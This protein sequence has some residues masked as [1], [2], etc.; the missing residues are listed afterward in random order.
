MLNSDDYSGNYIHYGVRE[1]ATAAIMNGMALHGGCIPYGGTFLVFSD[2]MRNSVR[3]AAMMGIKVV[4]VF[5]HDSIGLGE[6]GPT[7]QPIEHIASLRLI[8]NLT[9]IRPADANETAQAWKFALSNPSGP[10]ALMLTRQ[11]LPVVTD[12]VTAFKISKGA[13]VLSNSENAKVGLIATGSEVEIALAAQKILKEKGIASKVISMPSCELFD[14]QDES[15][16]TSVLPDDLKYVAIEAGVGDGWYKYVGK[17]G[18]VI[19]IDRFGASAP[20]KKIYEEFGITPQALAD[21]AAS[22]V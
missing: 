8:P 17:D 6:D 12:K 18:K 10:T 19:S 2:Y 4:F 16:K 13:Y 1:H 5:T 3:L 9:V 15:Y 22:L 21:T 14:K 11:G 20:Y 7:H